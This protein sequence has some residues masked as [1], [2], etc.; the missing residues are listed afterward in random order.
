MDSQFLSPDMALTATSL[1]RA[2]SDSGRVPRPEGGIS[3]PPS[4][5]ANFIARTATENLST[6]KQQFLHPT[7]AVP[8]IH[9]G[10]HRRVSSGSRDRGIGLIRLILGVD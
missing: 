9:R 3:Y 4:A 1:R 7:E 5:H 2:R 8:T 6:V 10:H